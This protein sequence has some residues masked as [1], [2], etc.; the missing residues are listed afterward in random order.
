MIQGP[1]IW[2]MDHPQLRRGLDRAISRWTYFVTERLDYW[3]I[4]IGIRLS[5]LGLC[6][7]EPG[8]E[9]YRS[10]HVGFLQLRC[11]L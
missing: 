6:W 2:P 8:D 9:G 3:T 11:R 7:K 5:D 4:W 10:E 1:Q